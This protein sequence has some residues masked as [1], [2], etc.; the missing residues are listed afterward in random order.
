MVIIALATEKHIPDIC[1]LWLEFMKYHTSL[2]ATIAPGEEFFTKGLESTTG[3]ERE[4]LRPAMISEK[5]LVQVAVEGNKAV[6]Y[7]VAEIQEVPNSEIKF[8]GVINHLRVTP[9]SRRRGAG[10]K[11]YDETI[12][13]FRSKDIKVVQVQLLAKNPLART[14]WRKE[15]FEDYQYT[16]IKKI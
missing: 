10:K 8:Y 9:G 16:W 13:W 4:F 15:G 3:F 14:F 7:C 2:D 12:K 1:G 6:G 11:L 5:R